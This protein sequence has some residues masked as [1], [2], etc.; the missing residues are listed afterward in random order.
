MIT[1]NQ[2][3]ALLDTLLD[4]TVAEAGLQRDLDT[5]NGYEARLRSRLETYQADTARAK[6]ALLD[7]VR[8]LFEEQAKALASLAWDQGS[9]A[10]D[11]EVCDLESDLWGGGDAPFIG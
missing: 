6:T 5:A 7:A 3:E 1:F 11:R 2:I 8:Q 9:G 10:P 4:E